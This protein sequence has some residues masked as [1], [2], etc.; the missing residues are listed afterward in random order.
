M[1]TDDICEQPFTEIE[2]AE[3][4]AESFYHHIT[5]AALEFGYVGI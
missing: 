5:D 1:K 3:F 4:F 2:S